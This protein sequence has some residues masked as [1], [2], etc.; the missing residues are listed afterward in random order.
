VHKIIKSNI[1]L[2]SVLVYKVDMKQTNF[3]FRLRSHPQDSSCMQ[4][5]QNLKESKIQTTSGPK[6][7]ACSKT[8][9]SSL[10]RWRLLCFHQCCPELGHVIS[11]AGVQPCPLLS[12]FWSLTRLELVSCRARG[13]SPVGICWKG[14]PAH[15]HTV[16]L[17]SQARVHIHLGSSWA[18]SSALL[19]LHQDFQGPRPHKV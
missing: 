1:N 14:N 13:Q 12:A 11:I 10:D 4:I 5:F 15:C 8:S 17:L 2:P 16:P 7:L 9:L 6:N 19:S 3:V 18:C